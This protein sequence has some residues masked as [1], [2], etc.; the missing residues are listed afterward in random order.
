[1]RIKLSDRGESVSDA[2]PSAAWREFSDP[3]EFEAR[4]QDIEQRLASLHADS[5]PV[6]LKSGPDTLNTALDLRVKID[7]VRWMLRVAKHL[8]GSSRERVLQT[9]RASLDQ[10]ETTVEAELRAA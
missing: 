2:R 5:S 3:G 8:A 7:A 9:V 6:S 4:L 1:M 10:L